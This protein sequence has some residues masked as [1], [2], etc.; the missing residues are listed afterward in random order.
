MKSPKTLM[1]AVAI[2]VM[3]SGAASAQPQTYNFITITG[4]AGSEGITD[5]TNSA[6]QF[7][8]PFGVAVDSGGNV[9]VADQGNSTIRKLTSVATNWVSRT[10]A[11]L[12][13]SPRSAESPTTKP[14]LAILAAVLVPVESPSPHG[15]ES[16]LNRSWTRL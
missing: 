11:G 3:C 8:V 6:V 7:A 4:V 2:S 12:T 5:G 10:I 13:G 14:G 9:Y 16:L 15:L 1:L